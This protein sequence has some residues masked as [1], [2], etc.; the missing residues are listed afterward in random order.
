MKVRQTLFSFAIFGSGVFVFLHAEQPAA[1]AIFTAAQAEAGHIAYDNTCGKCHTSTLLG[2]TGA[3]GEM[4]PLN[5]ISQAYQKFI[6][7]CGYVPS[8]AGPLFID[9]WGGKTA[10]QLISRF[11][12]TVDS[13]ELEGKNKDF[14]VNLTAYILQFNGAKAGQVPLTRTTDTMVR[15][16][17]P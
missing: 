1:S 3:P 14:T 8:L 2:R 16:T 12:E 9:R 7:P 10:A 4:P 5:S 17:L 15:S 13:F 11:Q 6:G